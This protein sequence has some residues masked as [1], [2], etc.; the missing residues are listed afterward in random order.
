[1]RLWNSSNGILCRET[2]EEETDEDEKDPLDSQA[3]SSN[4]PK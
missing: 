3:V 1:M 4:L 2:D